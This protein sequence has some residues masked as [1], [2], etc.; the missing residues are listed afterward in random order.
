MFPKSCHFATKVTSVDDIRPDSVEAGDGSE[1]GLYNVDQHHCTCRDKNSG[2]SGGPEHGRGTE[3][4]DV[5]N[6]E[7]LEIQC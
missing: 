4:A 3:V 1:C 7:D 2:L 5:T 6:G